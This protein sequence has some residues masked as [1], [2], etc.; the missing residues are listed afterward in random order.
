M[1]PEEDY[2]IVVEMLP[3][4]DIF[5]EKILHGWNWKHYV[6]MN[7]NQPRGNTVASYYL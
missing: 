3:V 1:R 4:D 5:D 6:I 2:S 7:T